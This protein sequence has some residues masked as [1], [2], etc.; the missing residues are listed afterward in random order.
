MSQVLYSVYMDLLEYY[1]V[2]FPHN[3]F[4]FLGHY[5]LSILETETHSHLPTI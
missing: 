3:V 4:D 1:L 5:H 2:P